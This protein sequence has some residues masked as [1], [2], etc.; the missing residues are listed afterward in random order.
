MEKGHGRYNGDEKR[1][2]TERS[3][4]LQIYEFFFVYPPAPLTQ[5]Q[6]EISAGFLENTVM[7][8]TFIH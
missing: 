6:F 4:L 8:K 5:K 3:E 7:S 1:R 2:I